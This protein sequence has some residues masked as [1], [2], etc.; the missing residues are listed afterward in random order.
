M[1]CGGYKKDGIFFKDRQELIAYLSDGIK[2]KT[3]TSVQEV[4]NDIIKESLS[5][6]NP[7][8]A[9]ASIF[10]S[11]SDFSR[12]DVSVLNNTFGSVANAAGKYFNYV[13]TGNLSVPN[14]SEVEGIFSKFSTSLKDMETSIDHSNGSSQKKIN[15][16]SGVKTFLNKIKNNDSRKFLP[17]QSGPEGAG[18]PGVL[19]ASK[20]KWFTEN[21]Q[22]AEG[23]KPS[24][25]G[26]NENVTTNEIGSTQGATENQNQGKGYLVEPIAPTR[27]GFG[28]PEQRQRDTAKYA[29]QIE[30]HPER[31]RIA[32]G[33]FISWDADTR[34]WRHVVTPASGG[35]WGIVRAASAREIAAAELEHKSKIIGPELFQIIGERGA[36]NLDKQ[37]GTSVRMDNLNVAI[38]MDSSDK[39]PATI[40]AATGWQKGADGKWKYEISDIV[41][42][43]KF[44]QARADSFNSD[45]EIEMLLGEAVKSEALFAAYPELR[46]YNLVV[47]PSNIIDYGHFDSL[48]K[49][50][51]VNNTKNYKTG[52]NKNQRPVL[53]HEI[54]HAIQEIEGFAIGGNQ[55]VDT[56]YDILAGE[57]E[58]RNVQE[59]IDFTDDKRQ[60]VLLE[61]T[62]DVARKYQ[63]L[64]FNDGDPRNNLDTLSKAGYIQLH[65]ADLHQLFKEQFDQAGVSLTDVSI[66]IGTDS[67]PL[68][69]EGQMNASGVDNYPN[70]PNTVLDPKFFYENIGF[71]P[72]HANVISFIYSKVPDAFNKTKTALKIAMELFYP[73]TTGIGVM[74]YLPYTKE[75]MYD[76]NTRYQQDPKGKL[77]D[78]FIHE[79]VSNDI[80]F[81]MERNKTVLDNILNV[82]KENNIELPQQYEDY[83]QATT[84]IKSFFKVGDRVRNGEDI[85]YVAGLDY[86]DPRNITYV[87][88]EP[89]R[90]AYYEMNMLEMDMFQ[91]FPFTPEEKVGN[92]VDDVT[93][94]LSM[95]GASGKYNVFSNTIHLNFDKLNKRTLYHEA[96]H[97]VFIK[98]LRIDKSKITEMHSIIESVLANGNEQE[99]DLARRLNLF[100]MN[101]G[102][103]EAATAKMPLDELRAHEF[104]SELISFLA[105]N[106]QSITP[107][108]E[109]SI[110]AKIID[111]F[112]N[113]LGWNKD[114]QLKDINDVIDFA[115]GISEKL[116]T[117]QVINFYDY[118][119][120]MSDQNITEGELFSIDSSNFFVKGKKFQLFDKIAKTVREVEV[121]LSGVNND[122][123]VFVDLK[124]RDGTTK[125]YRGID[126][127]LIERKD[128]AGEYI[129]ELAPGA[130]QQAQETYQSN[131]LTEEQKEGIRKS[132]L[133]KNP[134]GSY[135]Y[136]ADELIDIFLRRGLISGVTPNVLRSI[137]QLYRNSE[138]APKT[139]TPPPPKPPSDIITDQNYSDFIDK[140]I[141]SD[142]IVNHIASKF[143]A[144][145][146][147]DTLSRREKDILLSNRTGPDGTSVTERIYAAVNKLNVDSRNDSEPVEPPKKPPTGDTKQKST[148]E[149][150]ISRL[151]NMDIDNKSLNDFLKTGEMPELSSGGMGEYNSGFTMREKT[152]VP[153][154]PGTQDYFK[155]NLK[156]AFEVGSEI[157]ADL[158]GI[159]GD[160][161]VNKTLELLRTQNPSVVGVTLM[162]AVME[163]D[164]L[165]QRKENPDDLSRIVTAIKRVRRS[166]QAHIR[167]VSV[168]LNVRKLAYIE[169]SKSVSAT[170]VANLVFTSSEK[171]IRKEIKKE[172]EEGSVNDAA[173]D[174]NTIKNSTTAKPP[175]T[176]NGVGRKKTDKSN[177]KPKGEAYRSMLVDKIKEF[178]TKHC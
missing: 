1:A 25:T 45:K 96:A 93:N 26:A 59:R 54:Q 48:H 178:I 42:T 176:D 170:D 64:I 125:R 6:E 18:S 76:I 100:I 47:G 110:I 83:F 53:S 111:F 77:Q 175:K 46:N 162:Y 71:T 154:E 177:Y 43:D 20:D 80:S 137:I 116:R 17:T 38:Q 121:T 129:A 92:Q 163:N 51:F 21:A 161:Y 9:I 103:A 12:D 65:P 39:S 140:G 44:D 58:A 91:D 87:M 120:Y 50:F 149:N 169:R 117:G 19:S 81:G 75:E 114:L 153:P 98:G 128:K 108:S 79:F 78:V 31:V 156:R 13:Q 155:I 22:E 36:Y 30:R 84:N 144:A 173:T 109:Q 99:R 172:M 56:D 69:S 139:G 167:N 123:D 3:N 11:Y 8:V 160:N 72:A 148:L 151:S 86:S 90:N 136:T 118:S 24:S 115:N 135:E 41:T 4:K 138:P 70:L 68:I 27:Y 94:A 97:A 105:A 33:E 142:A 174:S 88:F 23:A 159:Y 106:S 171:K 32:S 55:M 119:Q 82:A 126:M 122:G 107:V 104:M 101:Y 49:E 7:S 166:S 37:D 29:G 158:K 14:K 102:E 145:K 62:E 73:E 130:Q 127:V 95:K 2:P 35:R 15:I 57:V 152:D 124:Y 134:D 143:H 141:V 66:A 61:N 146:G 63:D 112:K 74:N 85:L 132:S 67:Y 131:T 10:N 34:T 40:L 89:K 157:L 60:S 147:M 16:S 165:A 52:L 113:V 164:L 28:N 168:A 133:F 5:N 150:I